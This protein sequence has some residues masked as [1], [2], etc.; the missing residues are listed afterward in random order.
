[1]Y[2]TGAVVD[3][4]VVTWSTRTTAASCNDRISVG[5]INNNNINRESAAKLQQVVPPLP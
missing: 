1:M 5:N 4:F 3:K 2:V